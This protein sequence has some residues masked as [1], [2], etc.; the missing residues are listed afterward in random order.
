M[1]TY[2][3]SHAAKDMTLQPGLLTYS[4]FKSFCQRARQAVYDILTCDG[5]MYSSLQRV[6]I[7][8]EWC[9]APP[10]N[11]RRVVGTSWGPRE[12]CSH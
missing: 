12:S 10:T 8:R 11:H 4:T 9:P 7:D 3:N 1:L 6:T 5:R 2:R